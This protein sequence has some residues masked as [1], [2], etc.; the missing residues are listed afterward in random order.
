MLCH[1]KIDLRELAKSPWDTELLQYII[2][3]ELGSQGYNRDKC[4]YIEWYD[5]CFGVRHILFSKP[6]IKKG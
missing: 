5:D 6:N 4:D 1:H 2:S 3:W